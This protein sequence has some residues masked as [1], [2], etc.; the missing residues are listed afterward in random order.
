MLDTTVQMDRTTIA[1]PDGTNVYQIDAAVLAKG[2]LP[3]PNI[4]VYQ[5]IDTLDTTRDTFVR[6]ATPYDLENIDVTRTAAIAASQEYFLSSTLQRRYP[7]L[8]TA[9]QAKDAVRSR[10]DNSVQAWRT[11][12]TDFSGSDTNLHPTAEATYE[13]QLKDDYVAARDVRI[14]ADEA[15]V[16]ADA[17]LVLA[18]AAAANAVAISNIYRTDLNFTEQSY[19]IYWTL[20]YAAVNTF[21]T[22]MVDRFTAFKSDF[23]LI[24]SE[25]YISTGTIPGLTADEAAWLVHLQ[26]MEA[27]IATMNSASSN[28]AALDSA[29]GNFHT[30]VGGLYTS[31]QGVIASANV[32]VANAVTTKKEAEASLA[33]AQLAE[34]AA[35]AAVLAVCP[36]FDPSS[37]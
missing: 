23:A 10:I 32:T 19:V 29:F 13:Q 21:R 30:S 27:N 8:N 35:L 17:A 11:Y 20:Y 26:A 4:F 22:N 33:S 37:V 25:T 14:A 6:V 2:D 31:Q 34:D 16:T 28:G 9:V 18:Q 3:H 12:S 15:L 7:D 36:E 5:I 24:T 1:L